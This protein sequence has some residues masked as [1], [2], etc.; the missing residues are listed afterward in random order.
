MYHRPS[1]KRRERR[2]LAKLNLIPILDAVFIFIFF[3]LI[4]SS[5]IRLFEIGSNVPIL[6]SSPP[7]KN[8]K[9]LALTVVVS[10]KRITIRTGMPSVIVKTFD[11]S[12]SGFP[13]DKI[14]QYF[15]ALK[16]RNTREKTAIIE[17]GRSVEYETLIKLMDEI[18]ILKK[19]D[20][21]IYTKDKNGLDEK[22]E[23]LFDDIVFGNLTG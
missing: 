16:K 20:D 8:R 13:Y 4:S 7:P 1:G 11:Q 12:S 15:V 19:T 21:P 6:S 17:P 18:R 2:S 10:S 22:I 5:F 9:P 23:V 14:H 3:L